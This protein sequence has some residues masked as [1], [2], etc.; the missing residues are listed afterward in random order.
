[1]KNSNQNHENLIKIMKVEDEQQPSPFFD[2]LS[3]SNKKQYNKLK[4]VLS[5]S[6]FK[7]NRNKQI[8]TFYKMLDQIRSFCEKNDGEQWKKYLV[9]GICWLNGDIAVNTRR[10]R[11]TIGKSKSTINCALAKMGYETLTLKRRDPKTL[12]NKIPFLKDNS[13]EERQWTVRR[14]YQKNDTTLS[15]QQTEYYNKKE[16]SILD[17]FDDSDVID[18]FDDSN[19]LDMFIIEF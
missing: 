14:I 12:H 19:A 15:Q 11:I 17:V 16:S 1:L 4:N 5:S 10:L 6:D 8:D 2:L 18:M 7:H 9:C 3:D 13:M